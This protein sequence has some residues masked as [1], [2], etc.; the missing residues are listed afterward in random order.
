MRG[1][2]RG[3]WT[4]LSF[5][6]M[7]NAGL[8]KSRTVPGSYVTVWEQKHKQKQWQKRAE[9][10][11][12]R[13]KIW[14][15]M[16]QVGAAVLVLLAVLH[17]INQVMYVGPT[18]SG[19]VQESAVYG[20]EEK[21]GTDSDA[22]LDNGPSGTL[23]DGENVLE[24]EVEQGP[25]F[26]EQREQERWRQERLAW[27]RWKEKYRKQQEALKK[28]QEEEQEETYVYQPPRIIL[29]SDLHY[30]SSSLTDYGEAFTEMVE[31]DDGKVVELFG[32]VLEAF[33]DEMIEQKPTAVVLS[34]DL[35]LNGEVA[36]HRDLSQALRRLEEAGIQ[37]LAI[38]GN[39]DIRNYR[40]RTYF[41]DEAVP[42]DVVT[43]DEFYEYYKDYGYDEAL[44][45]DTASL[46][47]IYPL[48][49]YNWMMMLDTNQYE[50]ENLVNGK[51]KP[52]TYQW[53]E[54]QLEAADKLGVSVIPV[55]HHNLLGE[56]RYF[57]TECTMEGNEQLIELLEKYHV[58]LYMSGHLH[59]QRIKK[60]TA[61]PGADPDA[62]GIYEIVTSSLAMSP[63]QYSVL[64]WDGEGNLDYRTQSVDVSGWAA[65]TGQ[66]D[67][68]LLDFEEY[69]SEYLENI[70]RKQLSSK[71]RNLPEDV[72]HDMT[73]LYA[74]I[75]QDY[76]AGRMRVEREDKAT[77]AYVSWQR[78]LEDTDMFS[79]MG[80]MWKDMKV[81]FNSLVLPGAVVVP[82]IV[83][84]EKSENR[85]VD[86]RG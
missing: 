32:D 84:E 31:G 59:L 54:E 49:E 33:M 3:Y 78:F 15:R 40:N 19:E 57:T 39:H 68:R 85:Y 1:S 61:G 83:P 76:C 26:A 62:Y 38:P 18:Q 74:D 70:V 46:S 30:Y 52:A 25:G 2:V 75:Y 45:R 79:K 14:I 56:S 65:K 22:A 4:C 37:I 48:D 8:K 80:A 34:G 10:R 63:C 51:L 77:K 41:G 86:G 82:E 67:E 72:V 73:S 11:M 81:D 29:A 50:P 27:E 17:I 42:T 13:K 23:D 66:V 6:D 71:I 24:S 12:D 47:Y 16:V 9:I 43:A 28:K 53:I 5:F 69:S 44:A 35:T 60:H 36:S 58:P 21:K 64:T 7:I 20:T 55:G